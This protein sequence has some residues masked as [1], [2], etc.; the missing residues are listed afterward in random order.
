[1][2]HQRFLNNVQKCPNPKRF[3]PFQ[4]QLNIMFLKEMLILYCSKTNKC[5][6]IFDVTLQRSY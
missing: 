1:M 3:D 6:E 4:F 5:F 2:L